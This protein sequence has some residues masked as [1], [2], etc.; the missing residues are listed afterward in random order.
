MHASVHIQCLL[1][2][3]SSSLSAS[4]PP[5]STTRNHSHSVAFASQREWAYSASSAKA[6]Q[7]PHYPWSSPASCELWRM[8]TTTTFLDRFAA[9]NVL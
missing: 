6:A 8:V 1:P 7:L 5:C 9:Y 2:S 3:L 4:L